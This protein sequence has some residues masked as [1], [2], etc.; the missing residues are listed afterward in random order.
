MIRPL[1]LASIAALSLAACGA[2]DP[3]EPKDAA[4]APGSPAEPAATTPEAP[5]SAADKLTAQGFGPLRIGMTK[6]E[7]ETALGA[8]SNPNAVGGADPE[9]CDMF[10]PS[11]APEGLLVM[12]EGGR[13]TS[14]WL[15]K[16][17]AIETDRALNIGDPAAEVKRVYGSAATVTPHKYQDAPAEYVTAWS[18]SDHTSPAARGVKYEI[19]G[20]GKVSGIAG[21]GPSIEYVEGCA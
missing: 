1:A 2:P 9:S 8:D 7:V 18:S 3:V 4:P 20:D 14:V 13:L 17:T 19:G 16:N 10:H 12:L 21:G 6:A 5:V 15:R 11:R